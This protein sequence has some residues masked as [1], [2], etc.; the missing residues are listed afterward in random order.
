[1]NTSSRNSD[2][3]GF[4]TL[5]PAVVTGGVGAAAA[6]LVVAYVL[7]FPGLALPGPLV[8]AAIILALG[9][10]L[11]SVSRAAGAVQAFRV[12]LG[13][14]LLAGLVTLIAMGSALTDTAGSRDADQARASLPLMLAGWVAFTAALGAVAGALAARSAPKVTRDPV[15]WVPVLGATLAVSTLALITMGGIVTA[16]EAGLAVPDWPATFGAN[17]FLYPL[18][19]MTGGIY[20]EHAHRLMGAFVG[21]ATFALMLLCLFKNTS[22]GVKLLAVFAFLHVCVQGLVGGV[23]VTEAS[24]V[25]A[26][27][28]GVSAQVFL[29]VIT[30]LTL[31][32]T[33]AWREVSQT[34]SPAGARQR[35]A[36]IVAVVALFLQ[37]SLGAVARHF[38]DS[39][40]GVMTHV[41]FSLVAAGAIVYA[42]AHASRAAHEPLLGRLGKAC[43]HTVGLQMLLGVAALG[44]VMM[45][46]D[47]ATPHALDLTLTTAHQVVG[48]VL[49]S[50]T[51]LLTVWSFRTLRRES[52]PAAAFA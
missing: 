31:T 15:S 22:R 38:P 9:T 18:S 44:V 7:H 16:A 36:A 8:G 52:A 45:T 28:H 2:L 34:A 42:G 47:N 49:F 3:T 33:R 11:F 32:T 10:G 50:I 5:L 39:M 48:A 35:T 40:H 30:V 43:V 12:G 21:L 14:G 24:V 13:A 19:Q 37:V 1:M 29:A 25:F 51:A 20:Y 23:R 46:R 41:A 17:M 26:I 6:M 27:F 4:S